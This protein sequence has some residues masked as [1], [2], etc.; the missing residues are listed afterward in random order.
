[1]KKYTSIKVPVCWRDKEFLSVSDV[2]FE[3]LAMVLDDWYSGKVVSSDVNDFAEGIVELCGPGGL[4]DLPLSNPRSILINIIQHLDILY[5]EI[6][7]KEDVPALKEVLELGKTSPEDASTK[8]N[9]YLVS[10]D[11]AARQEMIDK[12]LA[13]GLGW[14]P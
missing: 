2:G 7:L 12:R 6:L 8:F 14:P 3:D 9:D 1:M 4:P 5:G 10:V 11:W 13:R